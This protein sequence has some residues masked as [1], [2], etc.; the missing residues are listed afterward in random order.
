MGVPISNVTRRVVFA[1]SGTGPYAFTFEILAATDIEVYKGDTLL[2]LTT[3]YTV[4]INTNGTGSVTLVATAGTDNITIIGARAIERTTDF[5]TGGDF[6]ANTV[7]TELDSLTIFAQQNAEAVDRALRAPE[8]DPTTINMTLPRKADRAGKY[9]AFDANGNPEPGDTAQDVAIVAANINSINTVKGEITP[10]NN[11]ST[12]AGAVAN[13]ATVAGISAN[14]TTVAG[15]SGNVTTVAGISADVTAVAGDATDIGLVA[16]VS[17]DVAAL[18]PIAADITAVAAIDTDITTL[19]AVDSDIA[20][21]G[22]AAADIT[23]V[24]GI[25]ADV[26][27]VAGDATDIGIVA[28]LST[29]IAALS[30][31]ASDITTVAGINTADLAAV[32]A[33]DTDVGTVAG[34]AANVTTVAGISANVTSVAGNAS[35]INQ[36]ASD[37]VAINAASANATAAANSATAAA[38]SATSA[39]NSAALANAVSLGNEPVAPSIRPSLNLDFA[40]VKALDPRITFTRTTTATYYDGVTTAKAEENL[41][42]QS[43][44]FNVTWGVTNLTVTGNTEVAPDGTTTADTL[45]ATA[46]NASIAQSITYGDGGSAVFSV[47]LKRK[48]GTG[49]IS[50][51]H[52]I[53]GST[54][55]VAVDGTWQRFSVTTTLSNGTRSVGIKLDTSGDEVY[56]WGAQLEVRA[57]MTAY[58]PTTTQPITNY[59]P[60]LLTAASGVARF[61]HN[62]VT[63]EGLG[64]LIEEQRTNLLVRSEE[65]DNAS[66]TKTDITVT[67]NN[68]VAPDGVLTADLITE[69]S[70]S[71]AGLT[72]LAAITVTSGATVTASFFVKRSA[73]IQW[74]RFNVVNS[75]G[76]N[77]GRVWLDIQNGVVGASANIGSGTATSGAITS[78]GN[79]WYRI[80]VTT[81]LASGDTATSLSLNSA[82]ANSSFTRVSGAAYWA[83]GAQLEGGAFPTSYIPTTSASVTRNADVASMTGTNF[84]SWYNAGEGSL[85]AESLLNRSLPASTFPSAVEIGDGTNN[86]RQ[87]VFAYQSGG[88]KFNFTGRVSNVEQWNLDSA[89]TVVANIAAAKFVGAYKVND[90]AFSVNAISPLTDTSATIPVVNALY[91]GYSGAGTN[92]FNGTIKKLAYY[93]IRATNAQLQALTS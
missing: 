80:S 88:N 83:W 47:W 15:I 56:A 39:A 82:S 89:S 52:T 11:I 23:T 81:T 3:D 61:D 41:L 43:Q 74:V 79:G 49:T 54:T 90:I 84:S 26:T 8:T 25:S 92:F 77:G 27:A 13:I 78:V 55:T 71:N 42:L 67:A 24:A 50:I 60:V 44:A 32:A 7:N 2:T 53:F 70:A 46:A 45:T 62:P 29:E 35:N 63:G 38:S 65:F 75:T 57:S 9:L 37:T 31:I 66:W 48:T 30:P 28:G 86:N 51:S 69:G 4:T 36:V 33:I 34:I 40:N 18:G 76:A 59:I 21:L 22:P 14:V 1:P 16:A 20:A 19:A 17:T 64:L 12:V 6:F 58:T 10:V 87:V 91:I 68:N 93:P 85:Y 5:V 72:L 73:L